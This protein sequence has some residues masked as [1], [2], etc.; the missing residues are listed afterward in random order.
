M[1]FAEL[2]HEKH[3]KNDSEIFTRDGDCQNKNTNMQLQL[4][5]LINRSINKNTFYFIWNVKTITM[6]QI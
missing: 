5:R 4:I 3:K 2:H 6:K 1:I